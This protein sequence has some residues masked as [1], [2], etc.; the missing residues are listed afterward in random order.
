MWRSAWLTLLLALSPPLL[1]VEPLNWALTSHPGVV[2]LRDGKPYDGLMVEY[3]QQM[4]AALGDVRLRYLPSNHQRA[5]MNMRHGRNLCTGPLLHSAE[6]DLIGFFVPLLISPPIQVVLPAS[7]VE[8]LPLLNGK[9]WLDQLLGSELLGGLIVQQIYPAKLQQARRANHAQLVEV[10]LT[11]SGDR[12]LLMLTRKRFDY[13]F[14]YPTTVAGFVHDNPQEVALV[15]VPVADFTDMPVFGSYCSRN[16]WGR[17]M[18]VRID[19]AART[20]LAE[21][22][23]IEASYQRWLPAET[24][25]QYGAQIKHFLR[26]RAQQAP[27]QFAPAGS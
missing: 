6:R 2:N 23:P 13:V 11:S 16:D 19:H 14:E 8:R 22:Q 5:L 12:L 10:N 3:L 25:Q 9:L 18:S 20:M 24:W 27:L 15:S 26:A 21:P 4:D 1:A 7:D 17:A